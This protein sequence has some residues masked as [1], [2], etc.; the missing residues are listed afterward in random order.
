MK[1]VKYYLLAAVMALSILPLP[2]Q[3]ASYTDVYDYDSYAGAVERLKALD[4]IAGYDD[5]SFRPSNILTRAEFA[6]IIVCALDKETIAKSNSVTTKF[7]DVAQNAWSVPYIN[8][9]F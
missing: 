1:K 7:Y 2:A 5:G 9:V 6:K 3:A 8:Y 4:I